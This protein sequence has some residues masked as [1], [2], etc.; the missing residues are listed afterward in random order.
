MRDGQRALGIAEGLATTLTRVETLESLAMAYA[1]LGR[2]PEAIDV[3]H[4]VIMT[5]M[6]QDQMSWLTHLNDNL[7]R[8][9]Q[10][11]PCRTPWAAVIFEK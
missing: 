10:G 5:A 11:Q 6:Q 3:Q 4:R 7:H 9:E 1:E 8:Y 2:F